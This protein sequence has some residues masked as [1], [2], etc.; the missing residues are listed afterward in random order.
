[1]SEYEIRFLEPVYLTFK[2]TPNWLLIQT[3]WW[4][5]CIGLCKSISDIA[6]V[7]VLLSPNY[8]AMVKPAL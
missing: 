1:M 8:C 7:I 2:I 5:R 6:I 4:K 3:N